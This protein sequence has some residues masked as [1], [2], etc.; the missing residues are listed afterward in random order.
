MNIIFIWHYLF[1]L[2]LK[3]G[4]SVK[5]SVRALV[6]VVVSYKLCINMTNEFN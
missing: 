5:T 1:Y 6:D 3:S 4:I 2:I